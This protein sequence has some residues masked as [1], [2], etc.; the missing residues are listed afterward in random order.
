MNN[1]VL[2]GYKIGKKNKGDGTNIPKSK[3]GQIKSFLPLK[4]EARRKKNVQHQN[5]LLKSNIK[6]LY[7]WLMNMM[8]PSYML[9][10]FFSKKN[11]VN[12]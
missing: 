2:S 1:D 10:T 3:I 7:S 9:V 6:H 12:L 4:F 5:Q 11:S 8:I